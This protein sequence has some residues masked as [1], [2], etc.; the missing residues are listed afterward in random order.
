[1]TYHLSDPIDCIP[2]APGGRTKSHAITNEEAKSMDNA[3]NENEI[4]LYPNPTNGVFQVQ[5]GTVTNGNLEVL[6]YTGKIVLKQNING[7]ALQLD[8]SEMPK[9]MYIIKVNSTNA[10]QVSK[11]IKN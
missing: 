4:N 2:A 5:L 6:D 7:N 8:I 9:G 3:K 10:Q 11:I 1:M